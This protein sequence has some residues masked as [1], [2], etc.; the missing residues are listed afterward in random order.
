MVSGAKLFSALTIAL[1]FIGALSCT[2][3]VPFGDGKLL[4]LADD[5]KRLWN[6]SQEEQKR[7]DNSGQLYQ[8]REVVDYVN[9]VA[10]KVRPKNLKA[11]KVSFEVKILK[12]PL[13]NAFALPHGV[14]YIHTGFLAKIGNEAQ[15]ATI[16]SHEMIH[17]T[18]R[19]TVQHFRTIQNTSAVLA[20]LQIGLIPAGP[21][22]LLGALLGS[23]GATAAVSGYSQAAETEADKKGFELMVMAG[24]D[25]GEAPKLFDH[26]KKDLEEQKM[27]EPFFFGSHPRLQERQDSY[28]S[29]LRHLYPDGEGERGAERFSEKIHHLLLDNARMDLAMGR[30]G[31]AMQSIE[32]FLKREPRSA[33]ALYDLG[34]VY[35]KRNEDGDQ[36]KAEK[37]YHL[38]IQY[39]PSYP[40]SYRGLGLIYLKQG[41]REKARA[42]LQRYL[43][44]APQAHDR[45]FIEQ[46]LKEPDSSK[47]KPT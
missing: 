17:I 2:T 36:P 6:R 34:E 41:H 19:H 44:L 27:E 21:Y 30:F 22:G 29:L 25:P 24:Y 9:A 13:L 31:W 1:S 14:I 45:G 28:A 42:E 46:Y 47:E 32:R 33:T 43:S 11:E 39:D 23:I 3:V 10:Q 40:P 12:N 20:T 37:Q 8:S 5:E 16:L 26:V 7:L 4:E 38:A 35:R 15:L 18:H